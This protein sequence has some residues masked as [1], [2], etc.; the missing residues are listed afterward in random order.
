MDFVGTV[1]RDRSTPAAWS[2]GRLLSWLPILVG[3]VH[4]MGCHSGA[5][6]PTSLPSAAWP[7][8]KEEVPCLDSPP[9]IA[10][11]PL[12]GVRK[13]VFLAGLAAGGSG[14]LI[15]SAFSLISYW[16]YAEA[17]GRDEWQQC[18]SGSS[19]AACPGAFRWQTAAQERERLA[20]TIMFSGL[21]LMTGTTVFAMIADSRPYR[22]RS[23]VSLAPFVSPNTGGAWV[24]FRF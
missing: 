11:R 9:L 21:F 24:Q 14:V 22:L 17:R 4:L 15:G 5:P 3:L 23:T 7:V 16:S 10:V 18:Y 6:G 13:Q 20:F 12:A 8:S 2:P 19:S 1:G